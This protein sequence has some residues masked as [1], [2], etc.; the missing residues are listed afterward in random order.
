[1]TR[2]DLR[3]TVPNL[4]RRF[5]STTLCAASKHPSLHESFLPSGS[6]ALDAA[7]GGGYGRGPGVVR[8][9]SRDDRP[10]FCAVDGRIRD[11]RIERQLSR[12]RCDYGYS[13]GFQ[14]N[15]IWVENGCRADFVVY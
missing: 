4:N 13:W 5:G 10:R 7:L 15:G 1:M 2:R 6:L 3:S 11:V 9:E 8:C 12:S 14:R